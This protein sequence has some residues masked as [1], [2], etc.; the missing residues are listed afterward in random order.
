M[1]ELLFE[2]VQPG[3]LI[4]YL[5]AIPVAVLP[6][7]GALLTWFGILSLL[8]SR[9]GRSRPERFIVAGIASSCVFLLVAFALLSDM[10]L[11]LA[12]WVDKTFRS[13]SSIEMSRVIAQH[14]SLRPQPHAGHSPR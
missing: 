14:A 12:Q 4:F 8:N 11:L 5:I 9:G 3:S 1:Y 2:R 10:P 6:L 7:I 13:Q